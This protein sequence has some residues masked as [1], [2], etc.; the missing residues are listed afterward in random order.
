MCYEEKTKMNMLKGY[1]SVIINLKE[2]KQ[3][4]TTKNESKYNLV[5]QQIGSDRKV[6]YGDNKAVLIARFM[7]QIKHNVRNEGVSFI[8]QYYLNKGLK[9][10]KEDGDKAA[11]GELEQ[12]VQRNCW[13][14]IHVEE[15][16]NLERKRAQDAMMLLAEKNTGE[17]KGR[18]VY[19]GNGTR[20]W[21]SR[22]DTSS[23]TASLEA[24][25]T[26]CVIDAHEGRDVM[27]T[28]L[29]NAFIQTPMDEDSR[30]MMKIT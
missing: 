10:F 8:Q 4:T 30:V 7:E 29:P 28:D 16:N 6:E 1:L 19:K 18:C 14:P 11:M 17:I 21:L 27:S 9:I 25:M 26:T 20:E 13:D 23:P 24:I 22:E 15:M 12:L 3:K 5:F 2:N